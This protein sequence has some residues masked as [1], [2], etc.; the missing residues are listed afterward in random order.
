MKRYMAKNVYQ[1]ALERIG[2]CFDSFDNVL[3]SF[4]GGKDSGVLLNLCYEYAKEHGL[5]HK[6]A[7]YHLDY[8]AQY[9]FTT[10]YVTR[11]FE[12]LHDVRRFW[13][14]LPVGANCGCKMDSDV[15]IP[16]HKPDKARWCRKMPT[17]KYVIN[18][19]NAPF[20]IEAGKKD[21]SV[22]DDFCQWFEREYGSTAV[23][24]GIR[25]DES[26][27]RN[28]M[29]RLV[30]WRPNPH[31]IFP[32]YDWKAEDI[33]TAYGKFGWDYN[34]LYDLYYQAGLRLPQMRVANPFHT[35]GLASLKLYRVIEPKIWG[36]LLNRINGV[37]FGRLY[38]GTSAL[39]FK[40][41][42]KPAH[43]TWEQ[44]A[45]FLMETNPN[46]IQ[47]DKIEE[48]VSKWKKQGYRKGIPDEADFFMEKKRDVP[49]W[50][51]ICKCILSNDFQ[52]KSL[53][54]STL[55]PK[56]IAELLEALRL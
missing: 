15:W 21:Y 16:W 10:D 53:G 55:R 40:A 32:I 12:R 20:H 33:F 48:Y 18:E 4:S 17:F 1:A 41:I 34:R 11:T 28:N 56:D 46:P 27:E 44:Y 42:Q 43:F 45:K 36:L 51:R 2:L 29:I 47:K 26:L 3:V 6:M 49:S 9:T 19:R 31:R 14:C 13:L 23:L 22:Q 54:F 30:G 52:C 50:R 7:F 38:G 8:E 24:I 5:L 35:C 25:A 39:A 37:N